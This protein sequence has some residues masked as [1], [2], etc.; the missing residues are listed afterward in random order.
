[1]TL[2]KDTPVLVRDFD[3]CVGQVVVCTISSSGLGHDR[4]ALLK[5]SG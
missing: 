1:V 4:I 5:T 2:C 3:D